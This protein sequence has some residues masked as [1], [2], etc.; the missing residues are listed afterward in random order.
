[1]HRT[2]AMAML[3]PGVSASRRRPLLGGVLILGG[4]VLPMILVVDVVI[5]RR[6]AVALG[7][8]AAF[9]TRAVV[10]GVIALATRVAAVLELWT[11]SGRPTRFDRLELTALGVSV[12]GLIGGTVVVAEVDGARRAVAP[13]F[14][15]V[16][17]VLFDA[18]ADIGPAAT[19]APPSPSHRSG[20]TSPTTVAPST[21]SSIDDLTIPVVT[22]VA[23]TTSTSTTTTTTLPPPLPA[24][25][26]SG[27]DRSLLVDVTTVLLLGGD[28]GPGR[29]G[30]RTDTIMLFSLHRPSG[31]AS[32][33]SIPRD[34]RRLLFPPGSALEARH[35]Y[36]FDG[37]VNAVYV[38]AS[39]NRSL[40]DAYRVEGVRAGV[41]ALAQGVGYSLDV[42]I[43]DYVLVD[44][45]GFVDLVDAIGGV[46]LDLAR[47]IPMP[48]NIP[49]AP[50]QYP[51]S[52]GP[53]VVEMDGSTALGYA[54]SRKADNDFRRAG[55]QRDLLAALAQQVS[56][57]DLARSY[58]DV[59]AAI[60]GTLRTSL[61]PDE[62]TDT[63]NVIGG[64][65]AIV[66][67][68]GLVPPL[69]SLTRPDFQAMAEVMGAVQLA[70]VRG[71]PSG[72]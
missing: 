19:A 47:P 67:S 31:R 37:L 52:I 7:L 62:L 61:T 29:V 41:V 23:T 44:M 64:E 30:L 6:N 10:V 68:V 72:Y 12:A 43:D 69:I 3:A 2:I 26:D 59:A 50:T 40:R 17:E 4:I 28:A 71:E 16:P 57:P 9:L 13:V 42:T 22:P 56:L 70:L 63:L 8:D 39:S 5:S 49:G 38:T 33:V 66:E 11:A 18:A 34:M 46:T 21:S 15:D 27:I 35:P 25:P 51:D 45:Q 20:S 55:R 60:G 58:G 36:G 65:T 32:L 54:R 14:D 53:G 24:R 48:G 1:M